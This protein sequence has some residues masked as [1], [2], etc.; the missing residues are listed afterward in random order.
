M[1]TLP[2]KKK[3]YDMILSGEKKEE[4]R[5]IKPYWDKRFKHSLYDITLENWINPIIKFAQGTVIFKNGYQRNAPKVKCF[6]E[7]RQ[8]YGK[9]EWGAKKGKLYYVLKILSVEE[10]K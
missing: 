8:G 3:W 1:L 2:I 10:V 4:Y 7:L 5:E 6:I 9:E